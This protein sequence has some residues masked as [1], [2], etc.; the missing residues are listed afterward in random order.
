MHIDSYWYIQSHTGTLHAMQLSQ[1]IEVARA[2]NEP[3]IAEVYDRS[4]WS[5]FFARTFSVHL[6][7]WGLLS[8]LLL[9][10]HIPAYTPNRS[11]FFCKFVE[12]NARFRRSFLFIPSQKHI[13]EAC[14][15]QIAKLKFTNEIKR[16]EFARLFSVYLPSRMQR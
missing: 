10:N 6:C 7:T 14:N 13:H 2:S 15:K 1:A 11:A 4:S 5:A 9:Q 16:K 8:I 3:G 12:N